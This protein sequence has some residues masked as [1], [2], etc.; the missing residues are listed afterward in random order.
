MLINGG[1]GANLKCF[2]KFNAFDTILRIGLFNDIGAFCIPAGGYGQYLLRTG[3]DTD[4]A[5]L[6]DPVFYANIHITL[7]FLAES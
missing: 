4:T 2:Q 5:S 7:Q 6:A 1:C 3:R